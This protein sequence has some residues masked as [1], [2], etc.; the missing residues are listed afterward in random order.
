MLYEVITNIES[1][2]LSPADTGIVSEP[3]V[4]FGFKAIL[5]HLEAIIPGFELEQKGGR[6]NFV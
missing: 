6:N 2:P 3:V 1:D 4:T 5:K